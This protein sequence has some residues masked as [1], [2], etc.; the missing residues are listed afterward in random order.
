LRVLF[1]IHGKTFEIVA[2]PMVSRHPRVVYVP[3]EFDPQPEKFAA[4]GFHPSEEGYRE[5]SQLIASQIADQFKDNAAK[6]E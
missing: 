1:G 2:R 3:T 6:N 4:E 5:F